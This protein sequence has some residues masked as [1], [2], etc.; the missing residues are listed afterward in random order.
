MRDIASNFS[1]A[2]FDLVNLL[3]ELDKRCGFVILENVE[4][5]NR[6][7]SDPWMNDPISQE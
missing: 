6:A 5:T 1:H 2:A 3:H 4:E 7:T